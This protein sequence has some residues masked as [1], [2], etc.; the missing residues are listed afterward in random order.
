MPLR[1][2]L[3]CV[4]Y[5]KRPAAP[6][7]DA[8]AKANRTVLF[9]QKEKRAL[10]WS[11]PLRVASTHIISPSWRGGGHGRQVK[12]MC[13]VRRHS[14]RSHVARRPTVPRGSGGGGGWCWRMQGWAVLCRAAGRRRRRGDSWTV[15]LDWGGCCPVTVCGSIVPW[16]CRVAAAAVTCGEHGCV[17]R[18]A[19][20]KV[21]E[22]SGGGGL[23][24]RCG[25]RHMSL[26][27]LRNR[28]C[29]P[30]ANKARRS[31]HVTAPHVS[32]QRRLRR[33]AAMAMLRPT[34]GAH[35]F[36]ASR[37]GTGGIVGSLNCRVSTAR[38]SS[39]TNAP[40]RRPPKPSSALS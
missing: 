38:R 29:L 2:M 26:R 36:G 1:K 35:P 25:H 23:R 4:L 18:R 10:C 39:R 12:V 34:Q 9:A 19:R 30:P 17:G 14:R 13:A 31:V 7:F 8:K 5:I 21:R 40:T 16:R 6:K 27:G 37:G 20:N 22:A 33:I 11:F 32:R 24:R 15:V 3:S 28:L